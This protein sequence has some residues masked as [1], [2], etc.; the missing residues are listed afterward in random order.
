MATMSSGKD[1]SGKHSIVDD[2]MY[3]SNVATAHVYIRMGRYIS[4]EQNN[5][6]PI[7]EWILWYTVTIMAYY[8]PQDE[9]YDRLYMTL[10]TCT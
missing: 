3:G 4:T 10:C 1:S 5:L 2:F 8:C 6:Y 9:M 7:N